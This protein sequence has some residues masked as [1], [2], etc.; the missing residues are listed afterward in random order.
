MT[1]ET[2]SAPSATPATT[3]DM[4]VYFDGSF[5]PLQHA[6]VSV[7]AHALHYGTGCFE[8]VRAYWDEAR[9]ELYV[10]KLTEHVDRF[11]RSCG[12]LRIRPT[13]TQ[14]ELCT[15]ILD[16]LRRNRF[17]SDVYIRPIAFKSSQTIKLTL[18]NLDDSFAVFA[19][20]FGHYAH[21]EGGLRVCLSPW[22]RI[23]DNTIP[24][25]AK[26]TG[27]YVNASLASD[28]ATQ[29]GFDEAL[30][31]NASGTL[32]EASS[33]NVFLV[34]GGTLITPSVSENILEGIT[35]EAVITL[36]RQE[37]GM[38]V[39]ER[40]VGRTEVYV[41]DELFLTGTGVQIEPV[42]SVDNRPVGTG[43]PG[44]VTT[45]LQTVYAQAVHNRLPP[46]GSWCTPVY[47]GHVVRPGD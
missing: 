1:A 9:E 35:R 22:R 45:R 7:A 11:F 27:G 16:V 28:D 31:L 8:G 3:D 14:D 18:T 19:F 5:M 40:T 25:R 24:A 46:Y 23:D 38:E 39:L 36:A 37:L 4:V 6:T 44:S 47:H 15:I 26:V 43:L 42:V 33:A 34:R 29:A 10:L 20:P 21:R 41:A 12:V 13:F 32:S 30:M 2:A 17:H